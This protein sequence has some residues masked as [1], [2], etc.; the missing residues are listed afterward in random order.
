LPLTVPDLSLM[1]LL[2]ADNSQRIP[3]NVTGP[4]FVSANCIACGLCIEL[5]KH[6][7]SLDFAGG[8]AFVS[9]QPRTDTDESALAKAAFEC[10]VNAITKADP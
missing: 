9:R 8:Y 2:V 7:I 4:W 5:A 6:S 3:A 1:R 10:P